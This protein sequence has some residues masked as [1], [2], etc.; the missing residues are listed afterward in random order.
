[1][2]LVL[3]A[4]IIRAGYD[5]IARGASREID[6]L[7][8]SLHAHDRWLRGRCERRVIIEMYVHVL[9]DIPT[10][11]IMLKPAILLAILCVAAPNSATAQKSALS[12]TAP[13][14]TAIARMGG[15]SVLASVERVRF[16]M[17]TQWQRS[18][19]D[20]RRYADQPSYEWNTDL[21]D[22]TTSSWRSTRRF[23][24][25]T[26]WRE[27]ADIVQDTVAIRR[28]PGGPG[29]VASPANVAAGTWA[30]LNIAYVDERKESFAMAPERLL[31]AMRAAGDL[32]T[33]AD[34]TIDGVPNARRI[35]T[36]LGVPT[37][38]YLRRT[39]GFLSGATFHA[40][41]TNDF[42]LV[43]WGEMT[44]ELWYSSWRKYPSGIVYP[45]QW[46][47]RRVGQPYKRMTVLAAAFNP[48]ASPDSFVVGDSVRAAY[49]KTATKPMHDIALDS[50]RIIEERFASFGTPGAP[51]GA[52]KL[53]DQWVLL[54][55]GYAPLSIER[56]T[57]WLAGAAS[58]SHVAA[59]LL[60]VPNAGSGGAGWLAA[61]KVPLY[62]G[63][64]AVVPTT[65]S[66][67][68]YGAPSSAVTAVRQGRWLRIGRDSLWMESIDLP[69]APGALLVYVPALQW[70]YTGMAAGALQLD[71]ALAH[72]RAAG[73]KVTRVGSLRGITADLP[74]A[75]RVADK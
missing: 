49:F 40:T 34:T 65:L 41:E 31:L 74:P 43:P 66:L 33:L 7:R 38:V 59:A 48:A 4:E 67:R 73:W 30:P 50:A 6:D 60:T 64:G 13:I 44:V 17:M 61:H 42:G 72:A 12:I 51:T 21:R 20:G 16:D 2:P 46:D 75:M 22:Y 68:G 23:L 53:G 26:T 15:A 45:H 70:M 36:L 8:R 69:D 58:S 57:S 54:E 62:A 47:V 14:D 5:E 19:F 39:D 37:T 10:A 9:H 25:G 24:A 18:V 3:P 29:G 55:G 35:A 27:I 63:R 32:R 28:S 71:I 11:E 1:M 52:V 56:A